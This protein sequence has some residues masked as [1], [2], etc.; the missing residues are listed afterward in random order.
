[1][2]RFGS[3]TPTG[4]LRYKVIKRQVVPGRELSFGEILKY[5]FPSPGCGKDVALWRLKN[6]PNL[7]RGLWR[8]AVAR[9]FGMPHFYGQLSYTVIRGDGQVIDLGLVSLRVVTT[10]GV[11]FIR[12]SFL[13]TKELENLKFHAFGTGTNAEN[14]SDT[15]LQ[16]EL[17]TQYA[18]D[19]TRPTGS[20]ASG[21][22]GAYTTVAT[23]SPD[24]GGT[25]AVT[26]HGIFDQAATGG[27]SLL[28]RTMAA[29]VN[30]TAGSDSLQAT[31]TYTTNAGS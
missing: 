29:A 4:T 25:I 28:D 5:G 21:G 20:Q 13:N 19:N 27:G 10:A 12:D 1:M 16:T 2:Q 15:A 11:N 26:E 7:W 14:A 31:Y 23:L 18:V 3:A 6:F 8:V 9:L 17:T 22:T 30:L 24:S